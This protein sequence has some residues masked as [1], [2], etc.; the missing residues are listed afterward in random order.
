[1]VFLREIVDRETALSELAYK[2]PMIQKTVRIMPAGKMNSDTPVGSIRLKMRMR[3][4]IS[5]TLRLFRDK[6]EISTI[7]AHQTVADNEGKS[8]RKLITVQVV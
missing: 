8:R 1:M 7:H 3:K 4:P 2:T 5:E 6:N